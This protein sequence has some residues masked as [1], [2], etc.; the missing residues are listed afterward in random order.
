MNDAVR[1]QTNAFL[2]TADLAGRPDFTLGLVVVSPS[3]RTIAGPGGTCDVEPR[4]MQVLLAL[5]DAAGEV[6]TR[7]TLFQRCWGSVF[8]G[9]DSLN[10]AIG[11]IR[12]LAVDVG[13]CSFE[14]ETIPRTGYRLTGE[15]RELVARGSPG[16]QEAQSSAIPRRALIGGAAALAFVGAGAWWRLERPAT[17]P[18]FDALMAK[19]DEA[20][21]NGA[22][23]DDA[24]VEED[25]GPNMIDLY[26]EATRIKPDSARAWGL[27]A[28]FTGLGTDDASAGQSSR[29]VAE[30]QEAIRR[31]RAIDP[32]EPNAGVA[33]FLFQGPMLDWA[34]RDRML[35]NILARDPGNLPAMTELMPLL[36]AAG[37]TRESWMWNERILHASP[38]AR[39]FLVIKSMKLWILGKAAESDHVI[40]RVRGLWPNY[41]FGFAIRLMLF[42]L[43]GRPKAALAMIQAR[44][45]LVSD[46]SF[47]K[48]A[49][50]ALD[51]HSPAAMTAVRD[52]SLETSRTKPWLTNM[53]VM[54]LCAL[55][56]KDDA[57]DLTEGYLLWR[58]KA[59][60]SKQSSGFEV[61]DYSRRMTQWLFTPPVA[62][63]RS[64]PRFLKLC[65]EFG[66]TDYWRARGVR[67]DYQIY[68]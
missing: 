38:F 28:Y 18:R 50:Q 61:N 24:S 1:V 65:G 22:A 47:W 60:S 12:K 10:R 44:P 4:V 42:A 25:H 57:F 51:S 5:A 31:A 16:A 21:R 13:G 59:V 41:Q 14:I 2:S 27:L 66:L 55:G 17:D 8:V 35:R 9:D 39:G 36:Q 30:S 32:N 67:P 6:V 48:A 20:F 7:E 43:T 26:R 29:L 3:T 58:G 54:V 46:V 56:L 64:D 40:N 37:L 49:A 34:E 45:D 15:A 68:G 63:M 23:L 33:M 62:I 19:G 52:I 11:A 53:A